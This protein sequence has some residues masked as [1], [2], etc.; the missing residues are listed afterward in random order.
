MVSY[1]VLQKLTI[2]FFV[3]VFLPFHDFRAFL[4]KQLKKLLKILLLCQLGVGFPQSLESL[5]V[6]RHEL[7]VADSRN[8]LVSFPVEASS[9]PKIVNI[10]CLLEKSHI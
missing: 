7:F 5:G 2:P 3:E 1:Q 6:E 9:S 10:F 4:D 8:E